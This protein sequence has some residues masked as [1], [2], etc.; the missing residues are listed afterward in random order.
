MKPVVL[1]HIE[2]GVPTII[3]GTPGVKVFFLDYDSFDPH[4]SYFSQVIDVPMSEEQIINY[5]NNELD[6]SDST[7]Q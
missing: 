7:N 2:G 6:D 4:P 5:I 3:G 1:I